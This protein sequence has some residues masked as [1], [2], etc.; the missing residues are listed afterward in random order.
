[1]FLFD[2][3]KK[4]EFLNA[5]KK[6]KKLYQ[7]EGEFIFIYGTAFYKGEKIE[8]NLEEIFFALKYNKLC[9]EEIIKEIEGNYFLLILIN[10]KYFFWTDRYG[11]L[12]IYFYYNEDTLI[13]SSLIY[14]IFKANPEFSINAFNLIEQGFQLVCLDNTTFLDKVFRMNIETL[15]IYTP[16]NLV[17]KK[18]KYSELDYSTYLFEKKIDISCWSIE[19]SI[20]NN[21]A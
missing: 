21:L 2:I 13:I 20:K 14:N 5:N 15:Y 4:E 19:R 6:S 7:N 18:I 9:Y 8:N 16:K 10:N 1:M 11:V 17:A 3:N 12:K